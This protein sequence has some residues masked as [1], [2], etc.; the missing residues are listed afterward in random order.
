MRVQSSVRKMKSFNLCPCSCWLWVLAGCAGTGGAASPSGQAAQPTSGAAAALRRRR[1]PP[2]PRRPRQLRR[3]RPPPPQ[4]PLQVAPS[5][6]RDHADG[7][8]YRHGS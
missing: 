4:P 8:G 7:T 1:P 5:L 2:L 6:L 3:R